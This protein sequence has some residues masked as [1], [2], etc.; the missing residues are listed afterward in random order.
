MQDKIQIVY[1]PVKK[2]TL[3]VK[4]TLE[5]ILTVPVDIKQAEIDNV[6]KKRHDWILQ[7]LSY[8]K[9]FNTLEPKELVSGENFEYLGRN[10]RLKV[11]ES[12]NESI[13]LIGGF[14]HIN[15]TDKANHNKKFQ[16][17]EAWY[18]DRAA[19]H[20]NQIIKKYIKVVN[21]EIAKVSI[22]K[23]KTRWGS[24]NPK[25]SYINLN[26][27]LIKKH[28]LAIEYVIFHELVHLIHYHHNQKFYNY[29]SV[30]MPDW[31]IRKSK[32]DL[33]CRS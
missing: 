1:K 12:S 29:L 16:L 4:P 18:K 19:Y 25:K 30:H 7:Q 21:K 3:K 15:L 2:I 33:H 28:P 9:K 26:L 32:L 10:Y 5:V 23:M 22:R 11:S 24:C 13:K 27:D 14:L 31:K 8:F 17:I 6:L 20:F